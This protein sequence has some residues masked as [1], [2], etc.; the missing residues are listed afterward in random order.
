MPPLIPTT[1]RARVTWLGY[2]PVPVDKLVITSAP[3]EVMPLSFA[4][5]VQATWYAGPVGRP[6]GPLSRSS[7][8][9]PNSDGSGSNS[10]E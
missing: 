4:G 7:E 1:H 3:V 5:S 9:L 2:Q 8:L 10:V 6:I